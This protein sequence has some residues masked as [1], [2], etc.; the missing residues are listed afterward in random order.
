MRGIVKGGLNDSGGGGLWEHDWSAYNTQYDWNTNNS[1]TVSGKSWGELL[2]ISGEGYL[3]FLR[4]SGSSFFSTGVPSVRLT[5]DGNVV[6]FDGLPESTHNRTGNIVYQPIVFKY[7]LKVEVYNN[8]TSSRQYAS[9]Y[10]CLIKNNNPNNG[11]QTLLSQSYRKVARNDTSSSAITEI[12]NVTGSGY[13]TGIEVSAHLLSGSSG[14]TQ[15][16]L[17]VDG[18]TKYF[19]MITL[20]LFSSDYSLHSFIGPIRFNSSLVVSH[21][22]SS[23]TLVA[24]SRVFYTLD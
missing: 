21:L 15:M 19:N 8:D 12:I 4:V 17:I 11:E 20:N 24:S 5:V 13:L 6:I 16:S 10:T 22:A 18:S 9:I 2:N 3:T 14:F 1:K 7:S 23:S